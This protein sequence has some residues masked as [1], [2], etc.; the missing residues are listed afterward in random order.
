MFN[1]NTIEIIEQYTHDCIKDRKDAKRKNS[2]INGNDEHDFSM[3]SNNSEDIQATREDDDLGFWNNIVRN[4]SDIKNKIK[5]NLIQIDNKF[6]LNDFRFIQIFDKTFNMK[7]NNNC[8][9]IGEYIFNEIIWMSYRNNFDP[10]V[11]NKCFYTSDA[12][13]GCMI[14]SGQMMLANAMY[15]IRSKSENNGHCMNDIL[16]LFLDNPIKYKHI[17]HNNQFDYLKHLYNDNTEGINKKESALNIKSS[18]SNDEFEYVTKLSDYD[19]AGSLITP[20]F[21]IKNILISS[22]KFEKG[23]GDWFSDNE[24]I[25][26][27]KELSDKYF[28]DDGPKILHFDEKMIYVDK[29]IEECFVKKVCNCKKYSKD[30]S[31]FIIDEDSE[32]I[33]IN[34]SNNNVYN[35]SLHCDCFKNCFLFY[36]TYYEMKRSFIIFASMR[37]GL[38]KLEDVYYE[39]VKE[40]FNI[41][42]NIGIIGGK[43]TRALFFIGHCD[44]SLIFLDP[45]YVQES[46]KIIDKTND[47]A[48][49]YR[50]IEFFHIESEKMT[51][52]ITIGFSCKNVNDFKETIKYIKEYQDKNQHSIIEIRDFHV[53]NPIISIYFN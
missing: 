40:Y 42:N 13:W 46:V 8:D 16:M 39:S 19:E 20:P 5:F 14:R 32:Y 10:V 4:I 51:P 27:L 24:I 25:K 53:R 33:I 21:S 44:K 31:D 2:N 35:K 11:Y 34:P 47:I 30:K 49:S 22:I 50:P 45:H 48:S 18:L 28:P 15:R 3:V 29:I 43:G 17:M 9:L 52:C 37:L 38:N 26:I 1:E 23:A 12:G 7:Y 6:K 36:N 41:P